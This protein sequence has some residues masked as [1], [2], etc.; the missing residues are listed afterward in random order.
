MNKPI[1]L[2]LLC[3]SLAFTSCDKKQ[4][5]Q[6]VY[7]TDSTGGNNIDGFD[8]SYYIPGLADISMNSFEEKSI[9]ILVEKNTITDK[10]VSLS[11]EGFPVNSSGSLSV[12]KG[13]PPFNTKLHIKIG[14]TPTGVY[15]IKIRTV[16]EGNQAKEYTFDLQI[17]PMGHTSC[18]D[19]FMKRFRQDANSL[20]SNSAD[21]V[22]TGNLSMKKSIDAQYELYLGNVLLYH[23]GTGFVSYKSSGNYYDPSTISPHHIKLKFDCNTY[24]IDIAEQYVLGK[25]NGSW[26]VDTFTVSGNGSVN[27]ATATYTINYK[28]T[29]DDNGT[30]KSIE[31]TVVGD[32]TE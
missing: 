11:V 16:A 22:P 18:V 10:R 3:A 25:L 8:D 14:L 24:K 15:P 13:Y 32:F 21:P 29:F 28:S 5:T 9:D 30:T 26:P 1:L 20:T 19:F 27:Y 7:L 17:M 6:V 12:Q 4:S 31:Y 23:E 2:L